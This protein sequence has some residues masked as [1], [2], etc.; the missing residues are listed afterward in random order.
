MIIVMI[1]KVTANK[2]NHFY[3]KSTSISFLTCKVSFLN[4]NF[5]F[6]F[7]IFKL[8]SVLSCSYLNQGK[9][10]TFNMLYNCDLI[11]GARYYIPQLS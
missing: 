3:L 11:I 7:W 6:F 9:L 10:I 1:T 2:P 8:D 4:H 5:F